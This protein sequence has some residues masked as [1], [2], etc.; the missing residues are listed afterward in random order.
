MAPGGSVRA[1]AVKQ[2]QGAAADHAGL[3]CNSFGWVS[4]WIA[5]GAKHKHGGRATMAYLAAHPE[6]ADNIH[7]IMG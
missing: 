7:V 4:S 1:P 6:E 5:V 2:A 3:T